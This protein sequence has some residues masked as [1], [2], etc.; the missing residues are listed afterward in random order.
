M[1]SFIENHYPIY[2]NSQYTYSV[3][4]ASTE[5]NKIYAPGSHF[6]PVQSIF[7]QDADMYLIFLSRNG[8]IYEKRVDDDW[9][10]TSA[11]PLGNL[12]IIKQGSTST[13]IYLPSEPA[14]P[15]GCVEQHQLCRTTSTTRKCGPMA[16]LRDAIA[17]AAVLFD[18]SYANFINN[19]ATTPQEALFL[20]FTN[21]LF[22]SP[23]F[24]EHT[25]GLGARA[26]H[27]QQT[28]SNGVQGSL[29]SNEW[30]LDVI[31]WFK[32][33]NAATQ[34]AYIQTAYG[35]VDPDVLRWRFNYTTPELQTLCYSQVYNSY[36]FRLLCPETN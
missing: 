17:G 28:F 33:S 5:N 23:R 26:L 19:T 4:K 21:A 11:A 10:R 14:S 29:P 31:N 2:S 24:V 15:L 9:Y 30:Q 20:Y 16:S 3:I 1:R 12:S 6:T 18:S 22:W 7:R 34:A 35:P 8:V 25:L 27:S 13:P 36:K 32:I